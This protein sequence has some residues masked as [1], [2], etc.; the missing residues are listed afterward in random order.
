MVVRREPSDSTI[1]L[2]P[3]LR[4]GYHALSLPTD[5]RFVKKLTLTFRIGLFGWNAQDIVTLRDLPRAH[6][7]GQSRRHFGW[8]EL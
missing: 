2:D 1:E 4:R 7:L 3:L 8:S 6:L 5:I